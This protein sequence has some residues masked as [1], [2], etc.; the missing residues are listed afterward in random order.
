MKSITIL[1][2][3][4]LL[5]STAR[6]RSVTFGG[7]RVPRSKDL[8]RPRRWKKMPASVAESRCPRCDPVAPGSRFSSN[9]GTGIRAGTGV[10]PTLRIGRLASAREGSCP[11][12]T[13]STRSF[14]SARGQ[15]GRTARP[16]RGAGGTRVRGRSPPAAACRRTSSRVVAGGQAH[17]LQCLGGP[18]SAAPRGRPRPGPPGPVRTARGASVPDRVRAARCCSRQLLGA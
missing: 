10:F 3:R 7:L 12:C 8:A 17:R 2:R 4:A 18:P 13:A 15:G 5:R 14:R 16:C 6:Q 1:R 9:A 11:R